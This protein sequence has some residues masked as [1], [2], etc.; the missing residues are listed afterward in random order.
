[1]RHHPPTDPVRDLT[2][3]FR[4]GKVDIDDLALCLAYW[5]G[6]SDMTQEQAGAQVG[7]SRDQVYRRTAKLK[8]ILSEAAPCTIEMAA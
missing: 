3:A 7:M 1:M 5:W 8:R 2:D 4:A 6:P